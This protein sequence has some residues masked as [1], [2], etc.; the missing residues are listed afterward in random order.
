M[1]HIA[2]NTDFECMSIL[3][4]YNTAPEAWDVANGFASE[5]SDIDRE[6]CVDVMSFDSMTDMNH[7]L[8][9]YN[10]SLYL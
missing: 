8:Y 10:A 9:N 7:Y 6:T 4:V 1:I 2:I 5:L 3:W